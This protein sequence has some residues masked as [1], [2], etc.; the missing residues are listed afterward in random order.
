M[1]VR[2]SGMPPQDVWDAFFDVEAILDRLGVD[3]SVADVVE[4]GCGYGTFTIPAARRV[5]G[6]VHTMDIEPAML[7][8]AARNAADAGIRNVEF[9]LRDFIAG[10]TGL[11]DQSVDFGF[12]FN[13]LHEQE[14]VVLLEEAHRNLRDGGRLGIIHWNCD[15]K[16]PR[17]PPLKIRPGPA[18]CRD[19]AIEAGFTSTG[20]IIDLPPWHYGLVMRR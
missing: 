16:T 20:E 7:E 17:G 14:P 8:V 19:W 12:L 2:E 1:K 9:T 5:S 18:Q 15:E 6:I 4:F 10:G 13:I 11:P 3:S